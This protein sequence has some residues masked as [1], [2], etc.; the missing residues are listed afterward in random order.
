MHIVSVYGTDSWRNISKTCAGLRQSPVNI[1][2]D[3]ARKKRNRSKISVQFTLD[4][5]Q[6]FGDLTNT[7]HSPVFTVN[8][9]RASAQ[10]TNV[11]NH[12]KDI[13]ILK[14][15]YFRFGC[16]SR[17]GS[18]HQFD[19]VSTPGEVCYSISFIHKKDLFVPGVSMSM[20][21]VGENI[22]NIIYKFNRDMM[23]KRR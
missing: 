5:G 10:L 8:V 19:G 11:P 23:G 3:R 20:I 14:K 4:N 6:V 21:F 2:H 9:S 15:I 1:R 12:R 18:E 13:Y 22:Q 7:G 16:T 17:S